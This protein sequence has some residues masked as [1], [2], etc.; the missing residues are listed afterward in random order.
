LIA[1]ATNGCP[2]CD[3]LQQGVAPF[4]KGWFATP[5]DG[6]VYQVSFNRKFDRDVLRCTAH[7]YQ[8][9]EKRIEEIRLEYYS[10]IGK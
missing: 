5:E 4:V 1:S 7:V 9:D 10:T 3:I 8:R 2:G 6:R